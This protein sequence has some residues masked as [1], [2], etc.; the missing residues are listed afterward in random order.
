MSLRRRDE[1]AVRVLTLARP[2][3]RNALDTALTRALVDGLREAEEDGEVRA[4]VLAGEGPSFCAGADLGEFKDLTPDHA[5]R[6]S[7]RAAL[8]AELQAAIPAM[9]KPVVTAWRGAAMGG[10]AGLALAADMTLVAPDARMAFPEIGHGIVP[11][12][13]MAI[14][15]RHFG[16][17]MA[18]ELVSTGRVMRAEELVA[19]EAANRIEANPEAAA[20]EVARAW[21]AASPQAMAASKRLMRQARDLD[22]A[23]AV[24]AG[25]AV[26]EA[27]RGFDR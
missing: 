8:T 7:A 18:F 26:N 15:V 19:R 13:V 5:D 12:L 11:A 23:A 10:G 6:V 1:G 9:G 4:V 3:R 17:K 27:M 16:H 14:L 21:S 22:F 25:R 2:E 20:M 24:E